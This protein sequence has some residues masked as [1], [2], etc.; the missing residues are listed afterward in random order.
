VANLVPVRK[1]SG[2]IRL[3]VDFRNLNKCSLKDNYPL[4]KMDHILQRVVAA[5][6]ISLLDGYSG[7]NQIAVCEEDKEK[8]TFTTPW[9][10]FTYDKMPF[11]LMNSRATFQRA[12]DID[13]VGEKNK[14]MVIHI[15]DIT[16]FSKFDEE[17]LQ[18]LEQVFNKCRRYGIS[19]NPKKSHFSMPEGKLLSHIILVGGI[20]VDPKRVCAIQQ[21]DIARNKKDVQSF[22]GKINFLRRFV[23]NFVEILKPI[24]NMLKKYAVIK[25]SLEEKSSFQTIKQY[26]VEAPVLAIPD[27]AK[28]F[29]IFS[30]VSEEMI[31]VVLLQ[32][33]EE[34]HE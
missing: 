2:E 10:K 17:H 9:G 8:T 3:C 20:K 16:I 22:I 14:F 31:V 29:F 21:I 11:G 24:T 6:I 34:G 13:F 33:N 5:H 19:L 4:L 28:Y 12:M 27:Y 1:K 15:D 23:L 25:W 30:F 32:K 7:Y 18:H 26:L